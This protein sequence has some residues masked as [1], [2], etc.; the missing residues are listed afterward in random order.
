VFRP[1]KKRFHGFFVLL[2]V[3]LLSGFFARF[4]S[5]FFGQD[6]EFGF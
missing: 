4:V 1:E 5:W 6:F 2:F 3:G